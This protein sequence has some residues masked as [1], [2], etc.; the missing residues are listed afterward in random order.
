[1]QCG[2]HKELSIPRQLSG[3]IDLEGFSKKSLLSL[4]TNVYEGK[5]DD[6]ANIFNVEHL[7]G[8]MTKGYGK[9]ISMVKYDSIDYSKLVHL[10][11]NVYQFCGAKN[12]QMM[13]DLTLLTKDQDKI[14][15]FNEFKKLAGTV[16]NDYQGTYLKAEYNAAIAGA[17][18]ASKWVDVEKTAQNKSMD[19]ILLQYRTAEDGRVRD[20]HKALNR[21]TRPASDPMWNT[22]Y[23]P[24][25][26]NCRCTVVKLNRGDVTSEKKRDESIGPVEIPKIFATNLG[27]EGLV[28]PKNSPYYIG[29]PEG[30][31][32]LKSANLKIQRAVMM[33]YAKEKLRTKKCK[34]VIGNVEFNMDAIGKVLSQPHRYDFEKNMLLYNIDEIM[35]DAK[36]HDSGPD[37]H[38]KFKWIYWLKNTINNHD[39][40]LMVKERYD[41]IKILYTI[42]DNNRKK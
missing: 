11:K 20:A 7:L 39:H 25:G 42:Q 8:A 14:R 17:Q 28:F 33:Q 15:P 21:I 31:D 18:M 38:N 9:H 13:K 32:A 2:G 16:L 26:W 23:P 22:Y 27:K 4:L 24:N 29:L 34:S 6:T 1:M 30:N 41:G 12:W 5:V 37:S 35:E 36:L 3:E 40:Y 19:D 10:E